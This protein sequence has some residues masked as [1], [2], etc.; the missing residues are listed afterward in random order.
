MQSTQKYS[1]FRDEVDAIV[2][3]F[4]FIDVTCFDPYTGSSS[5]VQ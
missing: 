2:P 5:G 1:V 3:T 4:V